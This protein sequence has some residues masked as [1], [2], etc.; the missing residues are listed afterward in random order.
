MSEFEEIMTE[1]NNLKE[2]VVADYDAAKAGSIKAANDVEGEA[3]KGAMAL[4]SIFAVHNA[5]IFAGIEALGAKLEAGFKAEI[6]KLKEELVK[7]KS[8]L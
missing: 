8:E 7:L 1:A 6:A 2:E 4:K 5:S 3:D